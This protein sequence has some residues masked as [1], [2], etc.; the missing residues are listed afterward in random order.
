VSAKR[1]TVPETLTAEEFLTLYGRLPDR[2]RAMATI[3]ATTGLRISE[4]LGLK[5][6]DIDFENGLAD[7][8][9]SVVD[10]LS[11]TASRRSRSSLFLSML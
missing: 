10:G 2:E 6:E 11:G 8:L 9:R 5:W 1:L 3:C 7:V 4:V